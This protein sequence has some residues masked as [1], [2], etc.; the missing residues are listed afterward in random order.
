M[1]HIMVFHFLHYVSLFVLLV[2]LR[3]ARRTFFHSAPPV[4]RR[5]LKRLKQQAPQILLRRENRDAEAQAFTMH[6]FSWMQHDLFFWRTVYCY[7]SGMYS[8]TWTG[9]LTAAWIISPSLRFHASTL[10]ECQLMSVYL[11]CVMS[12]GRLVQSF[13]GC[14]LAMECPWFPP[15]CDRCGQ[16]HSSEECPHFPLPRS[17]DRDAWMHFGN[18]PEVSV[19]DG[20][21]IVLR[22]A[23]VLAQPADGHCL[24]HSLSSAL[25]TFGIRV[26]G[27]TLR[28]EICAFLIAQADATYGDSNTWKQWILHEAETTVEKYCA[29]MRHRSD[30]GGN[31]TSAYGSYLL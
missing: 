5:T 1:S 29:S 30:R 27:L 6:L 16:Q 31:L 2:M 26:S 24:F 14:V 9:W 22:G 18:V 17:L 25:Q 20:N 3:S 23:T 15:E 21:N 12:E 28:C 8:T 19:D 13:V 7:Y 11:N 4:G 10:F